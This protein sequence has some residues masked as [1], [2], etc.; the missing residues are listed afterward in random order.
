MTAPGNY[1]PIHTGG[2]AVI[3]IEHQTL[4]SAGLREKERWSGGG[5]GTGPYKA[6]PNQGTI[7]ITNPVATANYQHYILLSWLPGMKFDF[8]DIRFTQQDGTTICPYWIETYTTKTTAGVWIKIPSAS[9]RQIL[10]FYGNSQAVSESDGD[11]VFDFFD[12]FP[13]SSIDTAKWTVSGSPTVTGGTL[14]ISP[15]KSV[16]GKTNFGV[17]YI[18]RVRMK[19]SA[20]GLTSIPYF[21]FRATGDGAFTWTN[22]PDGIFCIYTLVGASNTRVGISSNPSIDTYYTCEISRRS[23]TSVL[24]SVSGF[25]SVQSTTNIPSASVPITLATTGAAAPTVTYDWILIRKYAATEPTLTLK[26]YGPRPYAPIIYYPFLAPIT[27][28]FGGT[29]YVEDPIEFGCTYQMDT[30]VVH[31]T[32][33]PIS[34]GCTYQMATPTVHKNL[35]AIAFEVDYRVKL[36]A[37]VF[38]D[39][40]RVD[41]DE[42]GVSISRGVQDS[43]WKFSAGIDAFHDLDLSV[44]R[45]VTFTTTDHNDVPRTLFTGMLPA[46]TPE[47]A[48]AAEK[49]GIMGYDYAWY[50]TQQPVPDAYLHNTATANPATVIRA[51]LG[52]DDWMST[53]GIEP[54]R[55]NNVDEWGVTLN[56]KVFDFDRTVMIWT[57]IQRYCDYCRYVFLVKW[58]LLGLFLYPAAY[59]CHEDDIDDPVLGL[60]LP[61]PVTFT[62]P[63]G[64][65]SEDRI[66]IQN[67]NE[68]KYNRVIVI[69]RSSAGDVYFGT[70]E[71]ADVTNGD[72]LPVTYIENS[73]AFTTQVQVDARAVEL[74]AYYS[75]VSRT[76]RCKILDRVDLEYLQKIQFTGYTG[77]PEDWM[78]ITWIEYDV[79]A[80]KKIVEIEF[81]SDQKLS[82]IKRMYRCMTPDDVSETEAI[83]DSKMSNVAGND[84]GVVTAINDDGT[85]ATITLED[86]RVVTARI[87]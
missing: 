56:S 13:G 23:T 9:Q 69:G 29:H 82:S 68:E 51:M 6:W 85:E 86:G 55:I 26:Q 24:F 35:S 67:K 14:I 52:G 10:L 59:F 36:F 21:G 3:P 79:G 34:F 66:T 77:I 74:L 83:F 1:P 60:D 25:S 7:Q 53:T 20:F 63:S 61:D 17:N 2:L 32:Q 22:D 81:T 11:T 46:S 84:V 72:E 57:A 39:L 49:T 64:Y 75:T 44:M 38:L 42:E 78:R 27:P 30:P 33:T 4:L 71:T 5:G 28:E 50:L 40:D 80:A 12:D 65:V 70:A 76:Y 58:R 73:G 31:L 19:S 8:S 37:K 62:N 18:V 41:L 15:G 87:V 47:L 43:L 48:P 54:Y 16:V 45:H